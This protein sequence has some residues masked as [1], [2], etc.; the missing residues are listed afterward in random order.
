MSEKSKIKISSK[1]FRVTPGEKIKLRE[2]PTLVR[3]FASRCGISQ[4]WRR[5]REE[6][7]VWLPQSNQRNRGEAVAG[8]EFAAVVPACMYCH[9]EETH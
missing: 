5:S 2:W 1:D 7:S 9:R 4:P 6:E 3:P 8:I